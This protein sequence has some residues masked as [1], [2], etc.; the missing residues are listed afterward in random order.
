MSGFQVPTSRKLSLMRCWCFQFVRSINRFVSSRLCQKLGMRISRRRSGSTHLQL[1]A[2]TS[3]SAVFEIQLCGP[4]GRVKVL[5]TL[6]AWD[7]SDAS[8]KRIS[9]VFFLECHSAQLLPY[10]VHQL[11]SHQSNHLSSFF[12]SEKKNNFLFLKY[13]NVYKEFVQATLMLHHH[14]I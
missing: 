10:W 2:R 5:F 4:G 11:S 6:A 3:A 13:S 8:S 12:L 9:A 7:H 1:L 14:K